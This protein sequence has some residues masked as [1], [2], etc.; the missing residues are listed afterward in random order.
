MAN[1]VAAFL[2]Y[3]AV[4]IREDLEDVIYNVS[5]TDTPFLSNAAKMKA[6]QVKHEWQ[7]DAL[8]AATAGN[9]QFEGDDS[10]AATTVVPTVRLSNY[11]QISRKVMLISGTM[12]AVVKAG[13]AKELAYQLAKQGKELKRDMESSLTQNNGSTA[14]TSASLRYAASLESWLATNRVINSGSGIGTTPGF[15][16]STG[17]CTAP[18]DSTTAATL[19]QA[20]FKLAIQNAWTQGGSPKMV[21]CG[22]Y[23]KQK[24][25][26]FSGIATLFKD[27]PK[28]N[29]GM[30]IGAA[31]VYVSDFGEHMI[32]PNRFQRDQTVFVLDMEYFGVAYLRPFQTMQ[33]AKTGDAEKW[34]LLAEYT[35]VSKNEKASAKICDNSTS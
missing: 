19:T 4:G 23:N 3:Q 8:L 30:I 29:M 7:T 9:V 22:P 6:A 1:A 33:L 34:M 10:M 24:I 21:M 11:C 25:S 12:D 17:L 20:N 5:P 27:V 2:T 32:V 26:G 14:G 15:N 16:T 31:D 28:N 13:R 35:L 18:T